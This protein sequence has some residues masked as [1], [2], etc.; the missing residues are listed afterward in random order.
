MRLRSQA[1]IPPISWLQPELLGQI[2][3]WLPF[4]QLLKLGAATKS[5]GVVLTQQLH[6]V[7]TLDQHS[8]QLRGIR[9]DQLHYIF[10]HA[11]NLR[12]L[13]LR[14]CAWISD[15][16]LRSAWGNCMHTLDLSCCTLFT[17]A[18]L[19]HLLAKRQTLPN[20]EVLIC[21]CC[22]QLTDTALEPPLV[23]N[24][25]AS[26]L[27]G[28]KSVDFSFTCVS[29]RGMALLSA[30][31]PSLEK[32]VIQRQRSRC[33]GEICTTCCSA[34]PTKLCG[35]CRTF[36][37]CSKTCQIQDWD[38]QNAHHGV[39]PAI[40][41]K[42]LCG[43]VTNTCEQ[44]SNLSLDHLE[45]AQIADSCPRIQFLDLRGNSGLGDEALLVIGT[46][47]MLTSLFVCRCK[48]VSVHKLSHLLETSGLQTLGACG[49]KRDTRQEVAELVASHIEQSSSALTTTCTHLL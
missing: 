24:E 23:F 48:K 7:T 35:Q 27:L 34:G 29:G 17:N 19:Q 36:S 11:I 28:L 40:F 31:C 21:R 37:Y 44:R 12:Q 13:R 10:R 16:S 45:L 30:R 4:S 14:S 33:I 6:R 22:G 49:L 39:L 20:L 38:K 15:S 46:L 8:A 3:A 5:W 18:G 26:T 1:R 47:S 25:P 32:I 42:Q 43:F 9:R 41:H 2:A